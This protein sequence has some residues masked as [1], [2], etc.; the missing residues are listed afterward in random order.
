MCELWLEGVNVDLS[1][2]LKA[3]QQIWIKCSKQTEL[4]DVSS[5]A[6][7]HC[8]NSSGTEGMAVQKTC[9][10][11]PAFIFDFFSEGRWGDIKVDSC[12]KRRR[13]CSQRRETESG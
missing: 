1:C 13:C 3:P 2:E 5:L 7:P 12:V 8:K 9:A 11:P 10:A 4:C 6:E